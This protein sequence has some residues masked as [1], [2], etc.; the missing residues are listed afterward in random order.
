[1]IYLNPVTIPKDKM[2]TLQ[3]TI[4]SHRGKYVTNLNKYRLEVTHI[5]DWDEEV[6]C[7]MMGRYAHTSSVSN[8]V[9]SAEEEYIRTIDIR[10]DTRVGSSGS[11]SGSGDAMEVDGSEVGKSNDSTGGNTNTNTNGTSNSDNT[12]QNTQFNHNGYALVH[13]LYYPDSYDEWIPTGEVDSSYP[14]DILPTAHR[15]AP[16][17]CGN[18]ANPKGICNNT[19]RTLYPW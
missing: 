11:T 15:Y 4:T 5:L 2:K 14:P 17:C 18:K 13:W 16:S 19:G 1:M 10:N 7:V 9:G 12:L 3:E 8:T 6:D